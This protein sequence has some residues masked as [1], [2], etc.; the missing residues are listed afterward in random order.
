MLHLFASTEANV[1][2]FAHSETQTHKSVYANGHEPAQKKALSDY[3][4]TST[5]RDSQCV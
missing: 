4:S 1:C 2:P 3:E 5:C